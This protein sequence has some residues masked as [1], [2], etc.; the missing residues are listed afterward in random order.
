MIKYIDTVFIANSYICYIEYGD[1]GDMTENEILLVDEWYKK[2]KGCLFSYT[3]G[4]NLFKQCAIS[5]LLANCLEV[6]IY[7]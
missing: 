6:E 2:Y 7:K 5:G 3:G 1:T 4:D